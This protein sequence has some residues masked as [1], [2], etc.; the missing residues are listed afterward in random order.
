MVLQS[1][2][3][4]WLLQDLKDCT[5]HTVYTSGSSQSLEVP[6]NEI[7][8]PPQRQVQK[9]LSKTFIITLNAVVIGHAAI[10][11]VWHH[12]M[13]VKH[14]SILTAQIRNLSTH[15]ENKKM[16]RILQL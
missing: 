9:E 3:K 5:S 1:S 14:A 15:N 10:T 11:L 2:A 4:L 6:F 7:L 12:R 16:M 8:Q 13:Q